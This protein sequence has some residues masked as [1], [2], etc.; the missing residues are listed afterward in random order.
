MA[1]LFAPPGQVMIERRG[2]QPPFA[3]QVST[4]N[5]V[6]LAG[7]ERMDKSGTDMELMR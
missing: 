2:S 3:V 1:D 4:L 7:S 5:F 6:D